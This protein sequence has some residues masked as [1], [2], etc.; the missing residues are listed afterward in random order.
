MI[1]VTEEAKGLPKNV[2]YPEGVPED[3]VLRL[4]PV[5]PHP[6]NDESHSLMNASRSSLSRSVCVTGRP[7]GAPS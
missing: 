7:W 4:D 6:D 5:V 1:T 2:E 3:T